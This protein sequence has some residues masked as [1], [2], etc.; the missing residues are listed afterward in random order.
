MSSNKSEFQKATET[1]NNNVSVLSAYNKIPYALI[2]AEI[3]GSATDLLHEF[4]QI[5]G[6]YK[7]YKKGVDFVAE[8]TGGHYV[9]AQL[10]YKKAATL[11]NKEARF[12]FGQKPDINIESNGDVG[13]ITEEAKAMLTTYQ[14]LVDKILREN[15]FESI[16]LKAA[17]DCFIGKRIAAVVNFNE[18]NGVTLQFLS[19]VNFVYETRL[20][21]PEVLEKFV[22]FVIVKERSDLSAKRI[23]RK[24]FQLEY[25]KDGPVCYLEETL[26]DGSGNLVETIT[27][28]QPTLLD[29]IPATVIINDG[30]TGETEGESEIETLKAY[31]E[32]YSKLANADIDAER[33]GMNQIK[34]TVDM[35]TNSTRNLSTG[36]GAYWDLQSD[37]NLEHPA[38]S[39]GVINTDT[40]YSAALDT[41]LKRMRAS[42]YEEVDVP[43]ITLENIQ[44]MV[45]S[46]K[47]MKCLYWPLIVRCNEKMKTWSPALE[48]IINVI[49]QGAMVY[50]NCI[51]KYTE[52]ALSPVDY[53]VN[54]VQNYPLPEDEEAE[55]NLDLAEV[56]AN[57]MSRKAYMKKWRLLTD[58]EVDEELAQMALE[59]SIFEGTNME[60]TTVSENVD[61]EG[62][63]NDRDTDPIDGTPNDKD[64]PLEDNGDIDDDD[65]DDLE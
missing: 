42:M 40:T 17:K 29:R 38:P 27:E 2:N 33:K 4:G 32:W 37:Q 3:E 26:H 50:P 6:Y 54:I 62:N 39:V 1:N 36:P 43:D 14:N 18:E 12:L 22:C 41:T 34:Y 56:A 60:T 13:K 25:E 64:K 35:A 61:D 9:A 30:L 58:H 15:K 16:L 10:R 28:Y 11:I 20:D 8:G 53:E 52:D 5:M 24:K 7:A 31:E 44:G 49:I 57:T 63:I 55:K 51:T 23:F 21:N 45:T 19:S 46:G 65:I 48:Y 47:A 59:L